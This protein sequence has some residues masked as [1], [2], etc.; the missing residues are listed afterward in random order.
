[1]KKSNELHGA[2]KKNTRP[3]VV[4]EVPAK[5]AEKVLLP[6]KFITSFTGNAWLP[7]P[8]PP[9][10]VV[11]GHSA[12]LD[13]KQALVSTR[14]IGTA[15]DRDVS[16]NVVMLDLYAWKAYT[17]LIADSDPLNAITIIE[18]GGFRVRHAPL[19]EK[20]I[21]SVKKGTGPGTA[22]LI[23][24]A[25]GRRASYDWEYST[26]GEEWKSFGKSTPVAKTEITGLKSAC[27]YY[28]R[29]RGNTSKTEGD[30]CDPVAFIRL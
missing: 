1:M 15:A 30:W 19:R 20:Q 5:I 4:M 3:V 2:V 17:Q 13:A 28:F 14:T 29:Y 12:T 16:L 8:T 23:G 10:G 9:I 7:S 11:T 21:L 26:N 22:K 24:L 25:I 27:I 18:S 6:K